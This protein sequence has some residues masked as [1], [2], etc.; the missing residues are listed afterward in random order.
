MR[1]FT[2]VMAY[3]DNPQMLRT[4][5][6]SLGVMVDEVTEQLSVLVVDDGSQR[7]PAEEAIKSC[8]FGDPRELFKS[9]RLYRIDV[10]IP[11]NQDAARNIGMHEALTEWA[12]LTDMDHVVPEATWLSIMRKPLNPKKAYRFGRVSQPALTPYHPHPNSWAMTCKTFWKV[13]GYDERLA[14]NYGTDG[15]ILNRIR[16]QGRLDQLKDVLVRYPREVIPDASTTTLE[17]KNLDQKRR[18]NDLINL[19]TQAGAKPLHFQFPYRR[20]I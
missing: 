15:D 11:W 4:Q 20:V 12:L 17:R 19:R 2:L 6:Y 1:P 18:V 7:S 9:F 13:G 10:D 8:N 16:L 5:L 3:Y 14:G